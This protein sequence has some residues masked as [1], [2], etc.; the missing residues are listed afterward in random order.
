MSAPLLGP[1]GIW[2]TGLRFGDP[3]EIAEAAAE[4]EELGYSALWY[5][6]IG[7]E[8]FEAG[9]H[10]LGATTSITVA[11]GVLNLWM[12]EPEAA[13]A[14]YAALDAAHPGRFLLGIGVSHQPFVDGMKPGTFGKP[15]QA[16]H[17]FLDGID[18]ADPPVPPESRVLAAL[19]PKMLATARDRAAGAH[20][21]NTTPEH[22][23]VA[24]AALGPDRILA[25]EQRV[26]LE[27]DPAKAREAARAHLAVY[28][29]L[30]N[31]TN[32][33]LREG[34]TEEDITAPGSDRLIDALVAWGDEKAVAARVQAHLDAGAD[35]VAVQV[36]A[37][38]WGGL[39]RE[40]WR[41]LAA[42]LLPG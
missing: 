35:H 31:Y 42:V 34:F 1:I 16:M 11:T 2:N 30:P 7:G 21:Y 26:V 18:A 4:L 33:M 19:G 28:L 3:S 12:H 22:T 10:L 17:R 20:P 27:T 24:R 32:N 39:P 29:A 5:P 6:D 13:A 25:P 15:L 40:A 41:R 14:G 37:S 38:E 8:V 23:A 9:A 36:L